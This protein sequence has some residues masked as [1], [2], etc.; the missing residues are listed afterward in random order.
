MGV[1]IA[2]L[3]SAVYTA[4]ERSRAADCAERL[5][6][7]GIVL[8]LSASERRKLS[9]AKWNDFLSP[10]VEGEIDVFH[11]PSDVEKLEDDPSY[12]MND[13]I[14]RMISGDSEKIVMLDYA[15]LEVEPFADDVDELWH[16]EIRPRHLGEVNLL[17]YA[18][19]VVAA[20][21]E[22]ISPEDCE[23]L[24]EHWRPRRDAALAAL[25]CQDGD[26]SLAKNE[27]E[28]GSPEGESQE[29]ESAGG[30]SSSG[31][32]GVGGE[33]PD[34]SPAASPEELCSLDSDL[35]LS[36]PTGDYHF[37]VRGSEEKYVRGETSSVGHGG[38]E[39]WFYITVEGDLYELTPPIDR[40]TLEGT[41]IKHVGRDVYDDPSLLHDGADNGGEDGCE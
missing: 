1:L 14:R 12:G 3:A 22:D 4:N 24:D 5:R 8:Q 27:A 35:G 10:L 25:R 15:T 2:L 6:Q 34:G 40:A 30:G 38:A 26:S 39:A 18:G 31:S 21:P 32:G 20:H 37:N 41:M 7:V 13:R 28:E 33:Y 9:A 16:E 36:Q 17:K 29:G 11:C 23:L 19:H